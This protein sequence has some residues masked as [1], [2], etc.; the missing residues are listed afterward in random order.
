MTKSLI[1]CLLLSCL[2]VFIWWIPNRPQAANV[3]MPE[4]K[5]NS[6][7]Y[8]PYQAWQSP[9]DK[10]FPTP[11]QI[12]RDLALVKTQANGIRT[13]SALE[14]TLGQTLAR[15]KSGTDLVGLAKRQGLKVWLGIWLSAN[16]SDNAQEIAAG[17]A[18]AHAYPHTISRVVVGNEVL[19]RRDLSVGDLIKNI[20]YVRARVAQ[21]VAYADVTSFWLQFPQVA[22]HVDIVMV[23]ILPYWENTPLSV[24]QALTQISTV[25]AT[26]KRTFPGKEISI[27][28]TGWPSAG[29]WRGPAAPGRVNEAIF[30]RRFVTLADRE[31]VNYNIIEAFDQPWKYEDEGVAGANWGLWNAERRQKFSLNGPVAEHPDWPLYAALAIGAGWLLMGLTWVWRWRVAVVAFALSNGFALACLGTLPLLYDNWL[32]LDALVNLPLQALLALLAL[33]RAGNIWAGHSL[34]SPRSGAV[35]LAGL[36]RLHFT[37]DYDSLWFLALVSAAVFEALLVFD[38]RYREAPLAVFIVP[39]FVSLLRFFTKDLPHFGWEEKT[40]AAMLVGLAMVDCILEGPQNIQFMVWNG[41]AFILAAPALCPR[42]VI[43]QTA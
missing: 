7:S 9:M 38:G 2:T 22:P 31:H 3:R 10:S 1:G 40:A 39:V 21:P 36:R 15:I 17:I 16:P 42:R 30:L 28:E 13:Y 32:R 4:G 6:L 19:L 18:E 14:G 20:D 41:A 24:S 27:G 35:I 26:F 5:F 29:R 37:F 33:R 11:A 8:A 25:I 12:S 23:H 43:S 34:P